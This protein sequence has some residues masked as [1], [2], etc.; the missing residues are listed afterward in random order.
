MKCSI[1]FGSPKPTTVLEDTLHS[2]I[3]LILQHLKSNPPLGVV[4]H[5][6]QAHSLEEVLQVVLDP[7]V[8]VDLPICKTA[9]RRQDI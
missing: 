9:G 8:E 5:E 1:S 3:I 6:V 4:P 2:R 7:G